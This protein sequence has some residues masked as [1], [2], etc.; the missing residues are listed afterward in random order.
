[1]FAIILVRLLSGDI[2]SYDIWYP[3]YDTFLKFMSLFI[4]YSALFN[5]FKN[6]LRL[7]F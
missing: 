3:K 5:F 2:S 7:M 1:M 4:I 6:L